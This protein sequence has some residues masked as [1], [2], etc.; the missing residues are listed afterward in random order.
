M[1]HGKAVSSVT[2]AAVLVITRGTVQR[3]GREDGAKRK[4]RVRV[5]AREATMQGNVGHKGS[6]IIAEKR[7]IW[8][9]IAEKGNNRLRV[10]HRR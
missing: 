5:V 8:R 3:R 10:R 7:D 1:D 2:T 4:A 6:A 9:E